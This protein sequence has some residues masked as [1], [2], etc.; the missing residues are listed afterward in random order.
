MAYQ[1]NQGKSEIID[2]VAQAFQK[3]LPA[4]KAEQLTRFINKF[5]STVATDDLKL[6]SIDDLF[7]AAL[8]FWEFMHHRPA[9]DANIRVYNPQFETNAWQSTHTIIEVITDDMPFLV[10]SVLM[11]INRLGLTTH[12]IMNCGGLKICRDDN[13]DLISVIDDKDTKAKKCVI[14]AP[15]YVEIDRQ[16]DLDVL[17]E[18]Q[19]NLSRV[20]S[21]V[22][23]SVEDWEKMRDKV[24]DALSELEDLKKHLDKDEL[25][26]TR[27]F[28]NWI[29]NNHFTFLGCRDYEL[30]SE[31][32]ETV[33]KLLPN[34]GLGVLRDTSTSK[35]SR[36]LADM[37][38]EA[39]RLTLSGQIL[40][41][42]KTN[43][44][45]SVH[46][47]TYTDYIGIKRFDKKGKVIGERRII[48]L[49]TS[50]AYNASP[51]EIPFLRR[52]VAQIM[53]N[54]SLSERSHA[55]KVLL[56]IL[57]TLP[58]DDLFQGLLDIG[59]TK[60]KTCL[61]EVLSIGTQQHDLT[62]V[63]PCK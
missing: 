41:I 39:Q 18:L 9:N 33:L 2:K 43:T 46:R 63:K 32:G 45:S 51:R 19:D 35:V 16:T 52:K 56:N 13:D 29:T 62:P 50:A 17:N 7:G 40:I 1:F 53:R 4:E 6:H 44:Q 22:R 47:R 55:S 14:E 59:L 30:R 36:R 8:S 37:T 54:S 20:M 58:R 15:I 57:E 61:P 34:T 49:Y 10:D 25:E 42:S 23:I 3:R 48:G 12:F 5:Y 38:P 21:D 27:D 28:L 31:K 60:G 11:E 26:E 24:N